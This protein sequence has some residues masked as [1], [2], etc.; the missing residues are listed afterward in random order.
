MESPDPETLCEREDIECE[1]ETRSVTRGEL[2]AARDIET[3]V[4]VGVVNGGGDV[5]VSNDGSR[6]WTLPA[7]PVGHDD[8]WTATAS[9]V[10]EAVTGVDVT[11]DTPVRIRCI[12]F[13][14]DSGQTHTT[15]NIVVRTAP[16]SGRPVGDEPISTAATEESVGGTDEPIAP[17]PALEERLWIGRVPDGQADGIEADVRAVLE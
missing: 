7:A 9:R 10:A 16:V 3:H 4:T 13:R 5:L 1:T 12:E 15:Y 11:L 17:R 2:E 14:T 6:G 8:H